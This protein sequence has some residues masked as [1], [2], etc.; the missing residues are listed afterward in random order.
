MFENESE[1][2]ESTFAALG[3]GFGGSGQNRAMV[4]LKLRDFEE[5]EGIAELSAAS[6]AGRANMAFMQNRQAQVFV[7]QP[8]AI[9]ALRNTGGFSIYLVDQSGSGLEALSDAADELAALAQGDARLQSVR[10][11]G[12]EDESVL[13]LDIDQQKAES[14]GVSLSDIHAVLSVIFSGREV[15]EFIL[16]SS[17]R[18]VIVQGAAEYRMQPEDIEGWHA[19]NSQGEMVPFSAFVT[20]DWEPVAP[21]LAR[22][23]GSSAMEIQGSAGQSA[24]SGEAMDAMEELATELGGGYGVA[25]TG[26]SYQERQSGDQA[27]ILYA[28]S[29]L[30]AF[31]ALAAIYESWAI[32][33]TI[34]LV[35]P[36]GVFGA[37]L[38]AWGFGQSNDVYFKAEI[39]TTSGLAARSEILIVKVRRKPPSERDGSA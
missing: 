17:L 22:Y 36:V 25:W 5:R 8:P 3:F 35:V 13:R 33:L 37:L 19:R 39:L 23:G 7:M 16:G 1:A 18:P 27:P 30:I 4:F 29:V 9:M 15:N 32:P 6:V 24:S 34:M 38:T 26:L 14:F 10:S 28:L 12:G 20:T 31:L 11:E 21:S 2:S